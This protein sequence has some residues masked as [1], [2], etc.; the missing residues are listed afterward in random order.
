MSLPCHLHNESDGHARIL[1]GTA[2]SI[3]N[4]ELLAGQFVDCNFLNRFPGLNACRMV[5][6]LIFIGCPPYSVSGIFVHDNKLVFRGTSCINTGHYV[7]CTQF[8]DL[9][10]VKA[11]QI[12]LGLCLKQI[13][14]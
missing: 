5:V 14:I 12:C 13:L 10:L 11:L 3:Y 2:E 4:I 1:V 8:A 7:Y 6:V 9:S